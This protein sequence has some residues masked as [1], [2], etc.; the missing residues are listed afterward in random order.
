MDMNSLMSLGCS[1]LIGAKEARMR[2]ESNR[3]GGRKKG[4]TRERTHWYQS[5]KTMVYSWSQEMSFRRVSSL[6]NMMNGVARPCR[7]RS[8]RERSQLRFTVNR[9]DE[10]VGGSRRCTVQHS[11]HGSSRFPL[12][13]MPGSEGRIERGREEQIS[14][15]SDSAGRPP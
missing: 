2:S 14:G 13:A 10:G 3:N 8:V 7:R 15:R 9:S 1:S 12:A 6:G 4:G 11:D 5:L